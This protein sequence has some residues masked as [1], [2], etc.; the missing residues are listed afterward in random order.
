MSTPDGV[1][2]FT[3]SAGVRYAGESIADCLDTLVICPPE[4]YCPTCDA[5]RIAAAVA[6]KWLDAEL[7][8]GAPMQLPE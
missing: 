5:Y 1:A 3:F 6:T 7:Q 4:L 8:A 2:L